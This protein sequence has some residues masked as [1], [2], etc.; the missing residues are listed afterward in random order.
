MVFAVEEGWRKDNPTIGIKPVTNRTD[1]FHCWTEDEI[2]Q[3]EACHPI[4][5]RARLVSKVYSSVSQAITHVAA[6][7]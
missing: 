1:G 7:K 3:F 5:S 2:A 6:S 4:G